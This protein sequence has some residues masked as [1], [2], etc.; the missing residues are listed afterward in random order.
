VRAYDLGYHLNEIHDVEITTPTEGELLRYDS[1]SSIWENTDSLVIDS[2]GKVGIG[3]TSPSEKLDVV[4][5]MNLN[6]GSNNVMI[7][8][9]NSTITASNTVA[10]GFQAGAGLT[11]GGNNVLIGH[12][13]GSTLTT[14]SNKLYIENSNSSTPLI[15]G[16]FDN[17][18]LKVNGKLEAGNI[19][20]DDEGLS[21]AGEYGPGAEIWYQGS[22]SVQATGFCY[23]LDSSGEWSFANNRTSATTA[24]G[25]L[26]MSAGT[27]PDVDGMVLRGFV[28]LGHNLTGNVGDTVYLDSS[29]GRLSTTKPTTTGDFVRRV[30][31]LAKGINVIYFNPSIEWEAL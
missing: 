5:Q 13:A 30:G 20:V 2:T 18:Y 12:Q 19:T 8:S 21:A 27:D 22:N 4:G 28:R 23:Y 16:E 17:D 3:T 1:G 25:M 9:G 6:D 11:T 10:V 24:T 15:Y 14:E 31:Y 26:A 7:S 29:N